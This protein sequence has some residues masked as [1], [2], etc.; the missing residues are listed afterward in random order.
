MDFD[1]KKY[2]RLARIKLTTDEEEKLSKDVGS[3]L[4]YF[5]ELEELHTDK[6]KPVIGG[7]AL[8]NVFRE[9]KT[10]VSEKSTDQFKLR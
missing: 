6:V 2:A 5:K 10:S 1:I 7:S 3:I 8:K 9:D 4:E